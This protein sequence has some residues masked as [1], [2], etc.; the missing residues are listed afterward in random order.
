MNIAGRTNATNNLIDKFLITFILFTI[1]LLIRKLAH[2]TSHQ[3]GIN[4]SGEK[5]HNY[6]CFKYIVLHVF[7][8]HS[9]INSIS[10]ALNPNDWALASSHLSSFVPKKYSRPV[11]GQNTFRY[12]SGTGTFLTEKEI[13]FI[14]LP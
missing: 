7:N 12:F 13:T 3:K 10:F 9:L 8:Y 6:P 5:T 11:L 1:Y 14:S 4:Q 2:Q